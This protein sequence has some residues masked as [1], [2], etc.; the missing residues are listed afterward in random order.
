MKDNQSTAKVAVV[1]NA[2]NEEKHI[3]KTL[4]TLLNQ[5][6]LPYRIIVV[7][8]GSTDNTEKIVSK[9][10]EIEL[11]NRPQREENYVARKEL[12]YTVNAGL[13]RL[14]DDDECEYILLMSAEILLP[15]KLSV[16]NYF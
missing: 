15:K 11:I 6:L 1:L 13:E 7:N 3:E 9:F 12:A 14:S 2:R 4:K 5:E 8:D 10:K 16:R